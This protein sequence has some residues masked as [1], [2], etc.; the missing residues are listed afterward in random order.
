MFMSRISM[1]LTCLY[2]IFYNKVALLAG[3]YI[4]NILNDLNLVGYTRM[5]SI[6]EC[7][8]HDKWKTTIVATLLLPR[9]WLLENFNYLLWH[10]LWYPA[11]VQKNFSTVS[12]RRKVS[13]S[14]DS[15]ACEA[16]GCTQLTVCLYHLYHK[17]N[18][19]TL[20]WFSSHNFYLE[21]TNQ[22]WS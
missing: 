21:E 12:L 8:G 22:L 4:G 9:C 15:G 11:L 2:I 18:Q 1:S 10:V 19:Q 16:E 7:D 3:L 17:L 14:E 20:V 6:A 13:V 5:W